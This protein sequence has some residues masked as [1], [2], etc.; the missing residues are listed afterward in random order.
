MSIESP[1]APVRQQLRDALTGAIKARDRAAASVLRATL[2]AIENAEAID[3]A[4]AQGVA[5]IG[6]SLAVEQIAV[7]VGAAEAPRRLLTEQ[8]VRGIVRDEIAEREAAAGQYERVARPEQAERL[9]A[10]IAV[11]AAFL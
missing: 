1:S 2:G 7:G 8:D 10:E 9:R 4:E 6:R 11:L 3:P 5:G